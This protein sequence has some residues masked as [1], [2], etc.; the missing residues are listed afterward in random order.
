MKQNRKPCPFCASSE[1]QIA[2]DEFHVE[3]RNCKAQGPV[4]KTYEEAERLWNNRPSGK[5]DG[6]GKKH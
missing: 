3:C 1:T 6:H 5:G 2:F 4:A